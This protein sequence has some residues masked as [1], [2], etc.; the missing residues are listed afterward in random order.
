VAFLDK[1]WLPTIAWLLIAVAIHIQMAFYGLLLLAFLLPKPSTPSLG[2]IALAP[3]G[4]LFEPPNTAWREASRTN[5]SHY[6]LQWQWYEWL[7]VF[8]PLAILYGFA[9]WKAREAARLLHAMPQTG[10]TAP[11]QQAALA[12][13]CAW[14]CRRLLSFGAFVLL[15][16]VFTT[17][18]QQLERLTPYQPLRG[19]HLLY[20]F[21]FLFMGALLGEWVLDR[22]LWRWIALFLPL[23]LGMFYAQRQ[24]F[25]GSRHIEWPGL[26]PR[27]AWLQAFDWV[28]ANTPADAY[29]VLDPRYMDAV[30]EDKHGF[31]GLAERSQ[32]ADW[33][34][35]TGPVTLFPAI[36]PEWQRQVHALDGFE[37][38]QASDF[39]RLH[40]EFGVNW[41]VLQTQ[42]DGLECPYQNSSVRVCRIQ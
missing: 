8:A 5:T 31:R 9:W 22:K 12:L 30:G 16:A 6:L 26:A 28:A 42:V 27:N 23:A 39:R 18:P 35:D 14:F 4:E 38:F 34:K 19:Y 24:L 15:A 3:F 21:L 40:D 33:V 32:M 36:G 10:N 2:V 1:H 7:G 41:A 29:F 11:R 20:L 13:R 17:I 37:R 25:P